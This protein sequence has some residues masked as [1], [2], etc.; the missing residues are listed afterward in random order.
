M[1]YFSPN[2]ARRIRGK[3]EREINTSQ[4]GRG[5][6]FCFLRNRISRNILS[7]KKMSPS[8][9]FALHIILLG[10]SEGEKPWKAKF[11]SHI[12]YSD[13][14]LRLPWRKKC[15]IHIDK[16]LITQTI[17]YSTPYP[18]IQP[19][20]PG[21]KIIFEGQRTWIS[22]NNKKE[23]LIESWEGVKNLFS[24]LSIKESVTA[25]KEKKTFL[26][27]YR[28]HFSAQC[29]PPFPFHFLYTRRKKEKF[30]GFFLLP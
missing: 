9:A 2:I 11:V 23:I 7:R 22:P 18:L 28:G 25:P 10:K 6:L 26:F 29:R 12:R 8:A 30:Q 16:P 21:G 20:F 5:G 15:R 27:F 19:F 1:W 24:S 17:H 14:W 13:S 3:V 4:K